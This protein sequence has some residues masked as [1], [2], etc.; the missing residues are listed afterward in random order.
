[1]LSKNLQSFRSNGANKKAAVAAACL[2]VLL[3]VGTGR[4]ASA[5]TATKP[6]APV[7][8]ISILPT[9]ASPGEPA[10]V[11]IN[12]E[13]LSQPAFN[14]ALTA[15]YGTSLFQQWVQ[16]TLLKQACAQAGLKVGPADI[17]K[18]M[19]KVLA[20]LQAQHVPVGQR[21]AVLARLLA[22][23][24]QN[25]ADFE[26]SLAKTAYI[27]AL[28]KGHVDVTD[29]QI[30]TA[31]NI[32]YGPRVEVRDIVVRS[33]ED[34]ANVRQLIMH[35]QKDPAVVAAK[36][37]INQQNAAN[38]GLTIIPIEDPSL[39][40]LL[41]DTAKRLKP[42][43][44][45]PAIPLSNVYHLL[46]LVKKMPAASTPLSAVKGD[47]KEKLQRALDLQWG[48]Q[49]IQRLVKSATIKIDNPILAQEQ[50][51]LLAEI[52]AQQEAAKKRAASTPH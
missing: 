9:V 15:L 1:M 43:H 3:S 19:E 24:G 30:Q 2:A 33:L 41:T 50:Q 46:W 51:N 16:I 23:H 20:Q 11:E 39:P 45:S 36:M 37:S 27:L 18:Q 26:M 10:L 48:N 12:G 22:Q 5:A 47:L 42:G 6:A 4:Q 40:Q 49:E 13:R 38:G 52:K 32:Q 29:Q 25:M 7:K 44:L 14:D 17:Q 31:Y 21:R 35:E 8:S 34:A 28:A